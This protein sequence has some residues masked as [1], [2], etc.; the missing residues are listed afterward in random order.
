M[1][2]MTVMLSVLLMAGLAAAGSRGASDPP[3]RMAVREVCTV[4][5]CWQAEVAVHPA[6]RREGLMNRRQLAADRGMLFVFSRDGSH[7]F[8]ML[9][10]LIPLDLIWLDAEGR[11]VHVV[12]DAQPCPR[13]CPRFFS[14]LPARFVFEINAGQANHFGIET[15]TRFDLGGSRQPQA[16]SHRQA[17]G[18]YPM[19]SARDN[20]RCDETKGDTMT[21]QIHSTVFDDG[22]KIPMQYTCQGKDI[23]PPLSWEGIPAGAKSLVL[24][25]DDPDAPD[26][27][28]P[29]MTWVHWVLANLPA[30]ATGLAEGIQP[31]DLPAGTVEG[32]NDWGRNGYGGPCP[33]IGRHRYFHKLYALDTVLEGLSRPTKAQLEVAMQ[34]HVLAEA[35][36]VG[37]YSKSG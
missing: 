24:I 18:R 3:T 26:P 34:G 35:Q 30:S 23:S 2:G 29:K 6:D 12:R 5:H 31:A 7:P 28:A 22:G 15:G 10:T 13:N 1:R 9:N 8:W 17:V 32:V 20:A 37:T 14:P 25:V 16:R 33:P 36:L 4:R 11:V 21:M 27:Q 19:A